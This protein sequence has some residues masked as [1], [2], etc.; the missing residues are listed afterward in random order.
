MIQST[1]PIFDGIPNQPCLNYHRLA[2]LIPINLNFLQLLPPVVAHSDFT[3]NSL[4]V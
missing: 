4:A 1:K 3:L 2:F